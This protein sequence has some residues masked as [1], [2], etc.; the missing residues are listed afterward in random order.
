M[1]FYFFFGSTHSPNSCT[2]L[3]GS[4]SLGKSNTWLLWYALLQGQQ[5]WLAEPTPCLPSF[6]D[7]NG[8]VVNV[9]FS[10]WTCLAYLRSRCELG[11]MEIVRNKWVLHSTKNSKAFY[12]NKWVLHLT[13][14][15]KAFYRI[16]DRKVICWVVGHKDSN[17]NWSEM[18]GLWNDMV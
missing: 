9:A 7:L 2:Q 10:D 13:K 6:H 5:T 8:R 12:H 3:L 18:M 14:N 17:M 1:I 11:Q 16:S 4:L 15:S